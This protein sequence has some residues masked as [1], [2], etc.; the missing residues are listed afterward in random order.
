[1]KL[2]LACGSVHLNGWINI[3]VDDP[4]AD[5]HFDLRIPMPIPT[6]STDV[7]FSEHFIEHV[8]RREAV[9][10]LCECHRLLKP[11]GRLRLST[12]DLEWV[13]AKYLTGEIDHWKDVHFVCH[14]R[15]Q[16]MNESMRL[17]GH[18]WLYDAE[19]LRATLGEAGFHDVRDVPWRES[20]ITELR[21]L[22]ARPYHHE[23]IVEAVRGNEPAPPT[24]RATRQVR[25][26]VIRFARK[27]LGI[28]PAFK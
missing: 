4:A 16:L 24:P 3:D 13:V 17:W 20:E 19:D 1:M 6:A 9:H 7:I 15:C 22:E 27:R 10:F 11:G 8:T 2:H 5:R 18:Q 21:G 23:L 28:L 26:K 14:S 25:T 12:P